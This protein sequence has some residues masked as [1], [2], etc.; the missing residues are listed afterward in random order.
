MRM[1]KRSEKTAKDILICYNEQALHKMFEQ[2]GEVR[3]ARQLAKHIVENRKITK[4]NNIEAF[5]AMIAPVIIGNANKYLAP[6]FQALRIEVNDEFG[7]LKDLL[8]QSTDCLKEGG[9]LSIITFH[10]I[11]D[12]IVKQFIKNGCWEESEID[13][14]GN[15][16]TI[17]SIKL[18]YNKP[19]EPTKKETKNN[20][21]ARSARLRVSVKV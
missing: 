16:K 5:K 17:S 19:I 1:D 2:N 18:V 13:F 11:E 20:P 4:I 6:V 9:R 8:Q 14:L 10:S 12:R 15:K 3:N 7:A 21:R